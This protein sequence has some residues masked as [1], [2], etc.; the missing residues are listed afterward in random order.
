MRSVGNIEKLRSW[1]DF[2]MIINPQVPLHR[3]VLSLSEAL[4]LVSPSVADHQLRVA[5]ISTRMAR[6]MEY[7][8]EQLQNVFHAA[9]LYDIGFI[10]TENR[11][12]AV[13]CNE[14][15]GLGWHAEAGYELLKD[16]E[17]FAKAAAIVRHHHAVW[18]NRR[19]DESESV[20]IPLASYILA[21]ADIVDRSIRRGGPVLQQTKDIVK[22][23]RRGKA[24]EF[25]PDCVEAFLE[26]SASPASGSTLP[27]SVST[28][29]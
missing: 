15:E 7:R 18:S 2:L 26:V 9:A 8:G 16:N 24:T 5:Y 10:R 23:V 22:R 28:P 6:A 1:G 21:L 4:D 14:L 17:F 12:R 27:R 19:S 20:P 3:L 29:S 13:A 25:H 11:I